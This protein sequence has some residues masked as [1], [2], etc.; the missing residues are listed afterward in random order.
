MK[1]RIITILIAI[2]LINNVS[3]LAQDSRDRAKP[4]AIL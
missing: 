1:N 2:V 4:N 3:I